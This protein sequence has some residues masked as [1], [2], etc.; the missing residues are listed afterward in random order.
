V[1]ATDVAVD[2]LTFAVTSFKGKGT[3]AI[4]TLV[5]RSG[6]GRP[7]HSDHIWRS[8]RTGATVVTSL[9]DV[10]RRLWQPKP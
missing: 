3:A 8:H 10:W 5:E 1:Y 9:E 7:K 4:A 2:I 6:A